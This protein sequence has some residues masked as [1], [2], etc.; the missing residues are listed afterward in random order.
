MEFKVY[1]E[2]DFDVVVWMWKEVGWIE[3]D[4]QCMEFVYFFVVGV[5]EVV[6][7][8]GEVEC[9]VYCSFGSVYYVLFFGEGS[10]LRFLVIIVVIMSFIV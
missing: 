1:E 10:D 5:G 8:D 4:E 9:F 3:C 7:I 2:S 6:L